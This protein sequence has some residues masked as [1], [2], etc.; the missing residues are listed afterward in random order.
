MQ[1]ITSRKDVPI[2]LHQ[3][4][5]WIPLFS[6]FFASLLIPLDPDFGW[7]LKY[8]EY[9]VIHHQMQV[10]NLFSTEMPSYHYLNSAWGNDLIMYAI[11]HAGGFVGISIVGA[12]L[13]TGIFYFFAKAT[14]MVLAE[15][16]WIFPLLYMVLFLVAGNSL[17]DQFFTFLG[18]AIVYYIIAECEKGKT[19]KLFLTIPLFFLWANIHGE[20]ILGYGLFTIW[21]MIYMVRIYTDRVKKASRELLE[22]RYILYLSW[23]GIGVAT[24]INPYGIDLYR[25]IIRHANNPL[26]IIVTE[27]SPVDQFSIH[28]WYLLIWGIL[29]SIAIGI[30]FKR[31][32][33]QKH[34][35]YIVTTIGLYI[36]SFH[37]RRYI[38]PMVLISLPLMVWIPRM[39]YLSK[40][41]IYYLTTI[42]IS[43]L[44]IWYYSTFAFSHSNIFQMSWTRYCLYNGCSERSAEFLIQHHYPGKIFT[45]Y[46]WGGWLIWNYPQI[47]PSA[48]GRMTFWMDDNGYS[49]FARQFLFISNIKDIDKTDYAVVYIPPYLPLAYHLAYM[50]KQKKWSLVYQDQFSVI[51]V[52]Q[53]KKQ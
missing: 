38:Y 2:W 25:E 26:Q 52:K 37:I 34:S 28:W 10:T 46:N 9:Y 49:A 27:W 43:G 29:L 20:F 44:F 48:D 7:H 32:E 36:V 24:L 22:K 16:T 35:F 21:M 4:K 12:I 11:F 42:G 30:L 31:K 53:G 8:G 15:K 33:V 3:I 23:I 45:F 51:F 41:R 6:I 39:L 50:T 13:F 40:K 14:N 17:R 47:K 1:I 5:E 19:K 18:I